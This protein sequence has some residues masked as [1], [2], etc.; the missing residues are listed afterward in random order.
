MPNE[1]ETPHSTEIVNILKAIEKQRGFDPCGDVIYVLFLEAFEP[2]PDVKMTHLQYVLQ[3]LINTL[4]PH[5][6][7]SHVE[8][9]VPSTFPQEHV[10]FATYLSQKS[11][12]QSNY[13]NN[14]MYYLVDNVD[15]WRAIPLFAPNAAQSTRRVCNDNIGS[16]YS[17][18]QYITSCWPTRFISF[19]VPSWNGA[20]SHCGTLTSRILNKSLPGILRHRSA[21]YGPS[22]LYAELN[23]AL[24]INDN[25]GKGDRYTTIFTKETIGTT[26]KETQDLT[27]SI[28]HSA[29]TDLGAMNSE[30]ILSDIC[31]F[32]RINSMENKEDQKKLARAILRWGV[33]RRFM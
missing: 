30:T 25:K 5:P 10:N 1:V 9:L 21:W 28:L 24:S 17:L 29:D 33:H 16:S 15:K 12:W 4:Q 6:V 22:S 27:Q 31:D 32:A 2:G 8:L 14:E 19:M 18:S 3:L 13:D 11:D 26:T 20:P 7:M 23:A